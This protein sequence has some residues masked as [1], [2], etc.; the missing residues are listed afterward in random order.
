MEK[1]S[2]DPNQTQDLQATQSTSP[3][4]Q[5]GTLG[6]ELSPSVQTAIADGAQLGPYLI[7]SKLGEGGM[8][9]V[10]KARHTKLD[11]IV[12]LKVLPQQFTQKADSVARFEREMKAIGKLDHPQIV[13]AM[14][15]GEINGTHYLAMEYV[16]GTDMQALVRSKGP[17]SIA[18]ACKAIR[19]AAQALAA[20]HNEGLVHRDIKPAN[21]LVAKSGQIKILDL[22]LALLGDDSD[23]NTE[24]TRAGQTFGTPDYMAPEQWENVHG[25]DGRVDLYALGCT[26]YYL[27]VG[28]APYNTEQFKTAVGKMKAHVT[29]PIPSL[30]AIRKDVPAGLDAV[31]QKLMAKDPQDRY[32]NA[33]DVAEALAPYTSSKQVAKDAAKSESD[34]GETQVFSTEKPSSGSVK[35]NSE[36]IS[37]P[38]V[39]PALDLSPNRVKSNRSTASPANP[40]RK[41]ILFASVGAG[42]CLLGI[43]SFILSRG[44]SDGK[45]LAAND[46]TASA[47]N[48]E[49][50][51][52]AIKPNDA[53]SVFKDDQ[54]PST[55]PPEQDPPIESS[56]SKTDTV[57]PAITI[58]EEIKF[59]EGTDLAAERNAAKIALEELKIQQL[60]LRRIDTHELIAL[61]QDNKQLPSEDFVIVDVQFNQPSIND[62]NIQVFK[63][64]KN[65]N[66]IYIHDAPAL[67]TEGLDAFSDCIEL[68]ALILYYSTNISGKVFELLHKFPKLEHLQIEG[69]QAVNALD[70]VEVK[71]VPSLKRIRFYGTLLDDTAMTK[72]A[73][74]FPNVEA[75]EFDNDQPRH[76]TF[77]SIAKLPAL[78]SARCFSS[79]IT[80][81]G[82]AALAK[83]STLTDLTICYMPSD[84]TISMIAPLCKKLKSLTIITDSYTPNSLTE[85]TY[86]MLS[87]FVA[88]EKLHIQGTP[89]SPTDNSLQ[90]LAKL[91]KLK[92]LTLI[93]PEVPPW[94]QYPNLKRLYTETGILALRQARP[95]VTLAIDDLK[96]ASSG[97]EKPTI[98]LA[99]I[100]T[101]DDPD[102]SA[103]VKASLPKALS[104]QL[105]SDQLQ[106]PHGTPRPVGD[107][108]RELAFIPPPSS[109]KPKSATPISPRA[110]VTSPATIKDLISWSI[111]PL[112]HYLTLSGL[113]MHPD[114]T[115]I[116]T[117]ANDAT[118]RLWK[119]DPNKPKEIHLHK[120]LLGELGKILDVAWSNSGEFLAVAVDNLP[121]ESCVAFYDAKTGRRCAAI[122]LGS[123]YAA[124]LAWSPNDHHLLVPHNGR[125]SVLDIGTGKLRSTSTGTSATR[126]AWSPDGSEIVSIDA[127]GSVRFWN[128]K[129]LEPS[130]QS[131]DLRMVNNQ[132][133]AWSP[134][135]KTVAVGGAA[136][137]IVIIDPAVKRSVREIAL[138]HQSSVDNL[139]W[140]PLQADGKPFDTN[141]PRLLV[142]SS[143]AYILDSSFNKVSE[144]ATG[145]PIPKAAW[146]SD[147]RYVALAI[148]NKPV[149]FDSYTGNRMAEQ[150]LPPASV[151]Y[152]HSQ[153]SPD[154]KLLRCLNSNSML[155]FDAENGELLKKVGD[156]QGTTFATSPRDDW[157]A[158]YEPGNPN[159]SLRL[160][161]TATYLR[162]ELLLG[163][164]GPITS[165]NWSPTASI[166]ATSS[167][168]FSVRLWK[169][170]S[171][172]SLLTISHDR[173]VTNVLWSP[174]GKQLIS[175]TN[176]DIVRVW[177]AQSGTMIKQFNPLG[178][179]PAPGP[180]GLSISPNGQLLAVAP[181][182]ASAFVLNLGTGAV[183]ETLMSMEQSM[184]EVA[185]SPDGR[186]IA[187]ANGYNGMS[188]GIRS[189]TANNSLQS[190][191]IGT[192]IEW[193]ADS[194]RLVAGQNGAGSIQAVDIRKGVRTASIIPVT[195]KGHWL[196]IDG[197][198]HYRGSPGVEEEFAY[199][200]LTKDGSQLLMTPE[201]F[202]E[203][204]NWKN[205]P[206]KA[207]FLGG[208][209]K[210]R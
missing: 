104:Q 115:M 150:T 48:V 54:P 9:A 30:C 165:A 102:L 92:E 193:L 128:S 125:L 91:N 65:I 43:L 18:N 67:T 171:T 158:V 19:Q 76:I 209:T 17:M 134:D 182:N 12:A 199:V 155:L 1:N 28:H 57:E 202:R 89:G 185:W 61:N 5:E 83:H 70:V 148:G 119:Y 20:A 118:V 139:Y 131:L 138:E 95:D 31:Y 42:I 82:I 195:G 146:S 75:I 145:A 207:S 184:L 45:P 129:T 69:C 32:P 49:L 111:E 16:D 156:F 77:A 47:T 78:K 163:H 85:N 53:S 172:S 208:K 203:S 8:G 161:D 200:A 6:F 59:V 116:A 162:S 130:S 21:L 73:E 108:I 177:D 169:P 40:K 173:P 107:S 33:R 168:D 132:A 190:V 29:A 188:F 37:K 25:S 141:G 196:C 81:Q 147:A 160:V 144:I 197:E 170:G 80:P 205:D 68:K 204:Y 101:T 124:Q 87:G 187:V 122:S 38:P 178:T 64:C 60:V 117:T 175:C 35:I 157:L 46:K 74:A 166:L 15:A 98:Q 71:P 152:A 2:I 79:Q 3:N 181:H 174:D 121:G 86:K 109:L 4:T 62:A 105:N 210:T 34:L 154:G 88:L 84:A 114:G 143:P 100:A 120:I 72:L 164:T 126:A 52:I 7:E 127:G 176:A 103:L 110:F 24:L 63:A 183:S 27:L 137:R 66:R 36:A 167:T 96:F 51:T 22:G 133:L 58:P 10:Y 180:H 93:F 39:K 153:L 192:P 191:G 149:I 13:R 99:S 106:K 206:N 179:P 140:E 23:E 159:T 14:D 97:S 50:P 136:G 41:P 198:G 186:Y 11:K 194:R 112:T 26:L 55:M 201:Q 189:A 113:A 135:G 44:S 56:P 151:A 123:N 90:E 94:A 142:C